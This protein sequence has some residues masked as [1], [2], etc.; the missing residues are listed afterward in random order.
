MIL[1]RSR[2]SARPPEATPP[3]AL[4]GSDKRPLS[5]CRVAKRLPQPR[6]QPAPRSGVLT[7]PGPG[8]KRQAQ[9][10]SRRRRTLSEVNL[11]LPRVAVPNS[12]LKAQRPEPRL[13]VPQTRRGTSA[14][15]LPLAAR[16][17]PSNQSA[18]MESAP[19]RL[20]F[21]RNYWSSDMPINWSTN[22]LI[23]W[24]LGRRV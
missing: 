1:P 5:S 22:Q 4:Q 11:L 8:A 12:S 16:T 19:P 10:L 2:S 14:K 24:F 6:L 20:T 17:A 13:P 23:S 21:P 15:A 7:G 3:P 9:P 18:R